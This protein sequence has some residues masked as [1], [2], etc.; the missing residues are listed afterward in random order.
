MGL[1]LSTWMC[2][3][4]AAKSS[5]STAPGTSL[6]Y[7]TRFRDGPSVRSYRSTALSTEATASSRLSGLKLAHR[8]VCKQEV[9]GQEMVPDVLDGDATASDLNR[10]CVDRKWYRTSRMGTIRCLV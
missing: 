3:L 8:E 10:K 1:A 2:L 7:P 5:C 4:S 6:Q 9:C